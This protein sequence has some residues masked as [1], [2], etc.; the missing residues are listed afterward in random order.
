MARDFLSNFPLG[1]WA[2]S[3]QLERKIYLFNISQ[4]G[5]FSGNSLTNKLVL[6]SFV[7]FKCQ[8]ENIFTS[9]FWSPVKFSPFILANAIQ[10]KGELLTLSEVRNPLTSKC[11]CILFQFWCS[12]MGTSYWTSSLQRC[13]TSCRSLRCGYEQLNITHTKHLS[14]FL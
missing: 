14:R 3:A 4:F 2:N 9:D 12:I 8:W 1:S 10:F 13:R 5:L 6:P 11:G 7:S